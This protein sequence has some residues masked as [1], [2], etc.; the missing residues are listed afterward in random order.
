MRFGFIFLA[1]VGA[2]FNIG[3]AVI[4]TL[5]TIKMK[6]YSLR[7]SRQTDGNYKNIFHPEK[8]YAELT[9][10][11]LNRRQ[12]RSTAAYAKQ[13]LNPESYWY[14][15]TDNMNLYHQRYIA[16]YKKR[17]TLNMLSKYIKSIFSTNK[18]VAKKAVQLLAQYYNGTSGNTKL[19]AEDMDLVT[20][21]WINLNVSDLKY[22]PDSTFVR[23]SGE[24][25]LQD[26]IKI[27]K[28]LFAYWYVTIFFNN[29]ENNERLE[30]NRNSFLPDLIF[31]LM[32]LSA[33]APG[34]S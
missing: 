3:D 10:I 28:Q 8:E 21:W 15:F 31:K 30:F 4:G 12:A 20:S 2:S 18:R 34:L 9:A 1:I 11:K 25:Y 16:D 13:N 22:Q 6:Q 17:D 24:I 23:I 19:T 14:D 29:F 32:K 33:L 26:Q 5:F 27:T 7:Y